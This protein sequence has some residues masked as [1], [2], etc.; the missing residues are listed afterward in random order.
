[1]K[2]VFEKVSTSYVMSVILS[3]LH[4]LDQIRY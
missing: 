3:Y 4:Y 2:I 1:M